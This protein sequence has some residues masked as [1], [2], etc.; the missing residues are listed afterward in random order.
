MLFQN[1]QRLCRAVVSIQKWYRHWSVTREVRGHYLALR[2]AAVVT[3]AVWRGQRVRRELEVR[4]GHARDWLVQQN[5]SILY[6]CTYIYMMYVCTYVTVSR[7]DSMSPA[8]DTITY[9]PHSQ[10]AFRVGGTWVRGYLTYLLD[11]PKQHLVQKYCACA[12]CRPLNLHVFC[13]R[14]SSVQVRVHT[15]ICICVCLGISCVYM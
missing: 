13:L 3:Q 14:S 12:L 2:K 7:Q 8:K 15:C 10:V 5:E 11:V 4:E 6:T 1:Y 9:L